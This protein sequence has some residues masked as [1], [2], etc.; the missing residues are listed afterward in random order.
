MKRIELFHDNTNAAQELDNF[1]SPI[2]EDRVKVRK[3]CML[4]TCS[5][6]ERFCSLR[7]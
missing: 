2:E 7:N 6:H 5:Y 3:G 4:Q 1:S